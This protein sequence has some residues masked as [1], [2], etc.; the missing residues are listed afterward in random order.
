MPE[1]SI[2]GRRLAYEVRPV[3]LDKSS[4]S[5]VFIHGSGGDREDWCAQLNGLSDVANVIALE[6]PGHGASEP[7]GESTVEAYAQWVTDFVDALGLQK[8]VLVGCSLGSAITQRIALFT[9]NA[10]LV[11][12]GLV[13]AGARLRVHPAFLEGLRQD[14][15]KALAMLSDFCLSPTTGEPLRERLREKY[16]ET[17]AEL[18]RGDLSAC[19]EFDV[20]NS[21]HEV[22]LPTWILVGADDQLTP[23][24]F[25]RFLHEAIEGSRLAV[26]PQAGH[27]VMIERPEEFNRLLTEFLTELKG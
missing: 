1:V 14:K 12:I 4:L 27:L 11:G 20:M 21:I 26:V 9:P 2:R 10:W 7:P 19:N 16:L 17:S 5:V 15:Q 18:V 8:V 22:R 24:K 6:L 13:G 25:S 23:V 3:D